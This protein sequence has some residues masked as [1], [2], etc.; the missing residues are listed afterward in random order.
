QDGDI[1]IG[2]SSIDGKDILLDAANDVNLQSAANTVDSRSDSSQKSASVGV[3]LASGGVTVSGQLGK[4][5]TDEHSLS[6][7]ETTITA[8]QKLTVQS[9]NDTNLAGAQAKGDTVEVDVK[10][11]LNLASQQDRETYTEKNKSV[12]GSIGFG[13]GASVNL[14]ANTGKMDSEYRSV[15]EQT[16]IFAGKGGFD[17]KV[18]GNTDLK[19]A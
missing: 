10:G 3:D 14:S 6:Y 9:G 12:G 16:G 13:A 11:D 19:G 8:E 1:R 15:K 18:E 7:N 2:G 5:N 17:I 4:G